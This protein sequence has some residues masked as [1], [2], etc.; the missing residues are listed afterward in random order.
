MLE[1]IIGFESYY[2][3]CGWLFELEKMMQILSYDWQLAG[4]VCA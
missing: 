1:C 4:I 2:T 3:M